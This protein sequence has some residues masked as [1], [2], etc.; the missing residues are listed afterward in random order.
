MGR[1][2]DY[3]KE[4]C[5]VAGALSVV[6]DPWTLLILREAFNGVRRFDVW[7]ERLGVA[8]N[9][10]AARLKSLVEHGVLEA[11][12]YSQHPP[13]RD[14]VLT[15]KGRDLQPVLLALKAWGDRHIY[16]DAQ[17]P[18]QLTHA[19]GAELEPRLVCG[20][21]GEPVTGRDLTSRFHAAET[22]GERLAAVRAAEAAPT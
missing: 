15:A 11:R 17:R 19:C 14:Y 12:L 4:V 13:R 9:V 7:Q 20:A 1:T 3:S 22:V 2:A 18:L 6:G 8:R 16:R 10:L 21:C 5:P